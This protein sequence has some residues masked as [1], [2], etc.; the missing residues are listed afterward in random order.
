MFSVDRD[1]PELLGAALDYLAVHLPSPVYSLLIALISR[2]LA[3]LTFLTSLAHSDWNPHDILP[4]LITLLCAYLALL[5]LYR[6]TTWA[7]KTIFWFFKWGLILSVIFAG[8]GWYLH[9]ATGGDVAANIQ[10]VFDVVNI[11]IPKTT[12]GMQSASIPQTR[13]SSRIPR[14]WDSF[15]SHRRWREASQPHTNNQVDVERI[16]KS[17][18]EMAGSLLEKG[19]QWWQSIVQVGSDAKDQNDGPDSRSR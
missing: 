17:T 13:S 10:S 4:P 5:T 1:L 15:E 3:L 16:I 19:G 2:S 6:T 18:V 8:M 11:R 12:G 14:A 7:I 9:D